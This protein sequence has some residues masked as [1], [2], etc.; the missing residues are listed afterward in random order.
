MTPASSF[1]EVSG[2]MLLF[3][4]C[5]F[6]NVALTNTLGFQHVKDPGREFPAIRLMGTLGWIFI[7]VLIG[8]MKWEGTT[9]QF[10]VA[11]IRSLV[12][13]AISLGVLPHT[14]PK[15][16]GTKFSARTALGLDALV[17]MK[18]KA[19]FFFAIA[20]VLACIPLTF[21][22]SFTN[23]YLNEVHVPNAAGIMTLAQGSEVVM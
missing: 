13:V 12:M 4:L 7:T 11:L 19:F 14:P 20:S 5:Y 22:F 10:W 3:C 18:N 6:P 15:G 2:L 1:R 21:Y 17:M 9:G 23:T 16:K 8:F